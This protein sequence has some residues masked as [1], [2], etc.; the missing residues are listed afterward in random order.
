M[1]GWPWAT[2]RV[3]KL[4]YQYTK[5]ASLVCCNARPF[6]NYRRAVPA[7]LEVPQP[8]G[9]PRGAVLYRTELDWPP[10]CFPC[11]LPQKSRLQRSLSNTVGGHRVSHAFAALLTKGMHA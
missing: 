3:C 7:S 9:C 8:P 5:A 11:A 10:S 2:P 1:P 6:L 4:Y